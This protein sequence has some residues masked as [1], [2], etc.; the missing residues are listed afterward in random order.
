MNKASK[1]SVLTD[2]LELRDADFALL[3]RYRP[4]LEKETPTL[5]R[6]FYDYLLAHPAMAAVFRDFSSE[7]LGGC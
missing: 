4:L 6:D 2:F 5:A 3:D 7:R 1:I